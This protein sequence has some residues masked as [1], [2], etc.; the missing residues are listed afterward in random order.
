MQEEAVPEF[1]KIAGQITR[2][3]TSRGVKAGEPLKI[4]VL[5]KAQPNG[6]YEIGMLKEWTE[7]YYSGLNAIALA[8]HQRCQ[9]LPFCLL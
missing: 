2:F 6:L 7:K 9:V 8:K 5:T 4:H 1:E 3:R